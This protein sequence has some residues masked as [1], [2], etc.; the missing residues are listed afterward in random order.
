MSKT[1]LITGASSGF[2]RDTAEALSAAGHRVFASMRDIAGRNRPHADA[3]QAKG[4]HV[5]ELDVTDDASVERGVASVLENAG[6]LDVLVNNAGIGSAGIS[7]AF[8]TKQ[9]QALF[10]VNV[11][12]IQRTSRAVLPTFRKQGAGLIVNIGS[13]LGRVTFP[14]F[15]LYGASKFALEALTDSYRYELSTSG[16]DVVLVQPSNYPTNI[17][18]S[19]QRPAD[20]ARVPGY[21]DAGAIPDKMVETLMALFASDHAPNPHDVADAIVQLVAQA[22][23]TRAPRLI[24]GESFGADALNAQAASIQ[25][26][27]LEGLGLAHLAEPKGRSTAA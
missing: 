13:I 1:I 25:A 12:G 7:E 8:T 17:F 10:D 27:V 22:N 15:G 4:M 21:G 26:Q 20:A 24:V 6:H 9:V 2:G 16:I 18:A 11:F 23:G 19:A 5:I 14:F 3:L